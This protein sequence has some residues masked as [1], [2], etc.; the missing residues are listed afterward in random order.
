MKKI[1]IALGLLGSAI[2]SASEQ[3]VRQHGSHVHGAAALNIAVE[4]NELLIEFISPAINIV[5]FEHAPNNHEQEDQISEAI[6]RLEQADD[7]F[8]LP[9]QAMCEIEHAHVES[10]IMDDH[11]HEAE[12]HHEDGHEDEHE[13]GHDDDHGDDHAS[14]HDDGDHKDEHAHEHDDDHGDDHASKEEGDHEDEHAHEHDDHDNDGEAH[15]E[16]IAEY[17]FHCD[18]PGELSQL[19]VKLFESFPSTE[20]ID[21][22][23]LSLSGQSAQVLTK[24]NTKVNL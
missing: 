24:D 6:S 19:T 4:N 3:E 7:L 16:F 1:V 23:V 20:K 13:H 14:E 15:S 18:K 17:E 9:E 5:G 12:E 11:E 2:S 21:A 8:T 22:Q 10:T